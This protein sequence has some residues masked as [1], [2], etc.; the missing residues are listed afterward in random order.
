[1]FLKDFSESS[2]ANASQTVFQIE[3]YSRTHFLVNGT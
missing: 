3:E 2:Y 1:M